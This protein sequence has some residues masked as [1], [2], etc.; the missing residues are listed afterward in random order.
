[1]ATN[2]QKQSHV[3]ARPPPQTS[4]QGLAETKRTPLLRAV[5]VSD[6][7][8]MLQT[9][10]GHSFAGKGQIIIYAL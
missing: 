2:P 1:M 9:R 8:S 4:D 6:K 7:K 3:V 10:G 5:Q